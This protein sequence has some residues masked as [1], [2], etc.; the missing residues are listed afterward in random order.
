MRS[1][2][3]QRIADAI[4]L[5]LPALV[6]REC[7]LPQ[8]PNKTFAIIGMRRAGKTYYL[9]QIM[10]S[11]IATGVPKNRIVYFNFEDERLAE[12]TVT[13]LHWIT[14]EYYA[15][16]PETR[17]DRVYLFFDEIQLITGWERFVRRLMDTENVQI[18]ISGSS[19][20]MLSRE[21]A[22]SMRGRAVEETVY[23][24]SFREFLRSQQIE[25]PQQISRVDKNLRSL[26]ENKSNQYISEGGF[27]EAQQLSAHD[28]NQLL[29]GYV[30]TVIFRDIV[31]RYNATNV[32]ALRKLTR[33]L[34][35]HP[36]A[37][38]SINKFY[39]VLKSDGIK[40]AKTTLHEYL[41]YLQDAF[42][43]YTVNIHS[44]SDRQRMVNP[45]KTYV[46]DSGLAA[47][48]SASAT[49]EQGHLLENSILMELHRQKAQMEYITTSAGYEIDFYAR[50]PNGSRHLI[51]ASADVSTP[52]TLKR[53]SRA[54]LDADASINADKRLIINIGIEKTMEENG[55][56]I[57]LQPLWK[58]LLEPLI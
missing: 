27:P 2:I 51:Q 13:D 41:E 44:K 17:T 20:K 26:L 14:D 40:V 35:Q 21:I 12:M 32:I 30:D 34:L 48:Y 22:S 55:Q 28:R 57:L 24:F 8:I 52:E 15:M 7:R 1:I 53:E 42:L 58:W 10:K 31:E 36:G 18:Y 6:E 45:M 46:C 29:Q 25:V 47:A 4:A 11:L 49:V 23:P 43:V 54:L 56:T 16:F 3:R 9:Y 39:N 50:F 38:F 33:H 19:A 5:E 37:K